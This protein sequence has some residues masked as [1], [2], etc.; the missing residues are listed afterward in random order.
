MRTTPRAAPAAGGQPRDQRTAA[1]GQVPIDG[2]VAA[3]SEQMFQ[4]LVSSVQDYAIFMLDPWGRIA[5]WNEGAARIKGY[6][7]QEIIGQHFS[8][9]YPERDVSAG[10]PEWELIVA[11]DTG[12]YEDEGWRVRKDGN[13]FWANVVITALRDESGNLKGFG[14]VTRD[15]TSRRRAELERVERERKEADLLRA[16]AARLAELERTKTEF[17]NLASHELRGPLAVARGFLSLLLD[18]SIT[19]GEFLRHAPVVEGRLSQIEWLVQKMLETARLE[20]DRFV[21][22]LKDFDIVA[23]V[24]EQIDAV[25]PL[26]SGAHHLTVDM[27]PAEDLIVEGDRDRIGIA[28]VNLLDNAVKYS[29]EGGTIHVIVAAAAGR[30]FVSVSDQ[31][32]GIDTHDLPKLFGR[33]TRLHG[34]ELT[35]IGGTGL[36]LYLAREIA[37]RHGGDIIVES[38]RGVGSRFTLSLALQPSAPARPRPARDPAA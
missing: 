24:R 5:S 37:R 25:K 1:A 23:V 15:L 28:I 12:R 14:K 19:P 26:L 35:N 38:E 21:V 17:L 20:H 2:G 6:A 3:A 16:H 8:V 4:L 18:G 10:K 11:A 22:S 27:L 13:Q 9:F 34:D 31:G 33:F 36:G 29:P 7:A 30:A 32:I